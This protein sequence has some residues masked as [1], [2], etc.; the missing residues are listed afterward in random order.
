MIEN[1]AS[2]EDS[3]PEAETA[4]AKPK[5]TVK[6]IHHHH[7]KNG[8]AQINFGRIAFGLILIFIGVVY[9]AQSTGWIN[10]NFS[11]DW[12]KLW[13]LLIIIFGLSI[14]SGRGW[15]SGLIGLLVTL[16]L[17][18]IVALLIFGNGNVS[19]STTTEPISINLEAGAT[20]AILNVKAG[21]GK[22]TLTGGSDKLVDG[23][24]ES[25]S[26]DLTITSVLDGDTQ[27]VTLEEES[28]NWKN[29]GRHINDLELELDNN[30]PIKIIVNSGAMDMKLDLKDVTA[31]S[32]E[33]NTGASS[34]NLELGDK[35]ANSAVSIDAGAS[36]LT[37]NL[38]KTLGAKLNI[39]AGL[40]S[41]DLPEFNKIDDKHYESNNYSA[42]EKKVDIDLDMGVS[43]LKVNWR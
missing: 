8:G 2:P 24:F 41:K 6:E 23:T 37:L 27:T 16:A 19:T 35:I 21:A 36:S 22:L 34:M 29:L 28:F 30:L 18:A 17:L 31:E 9:L 40:S 32:V 25:N 12:W 38:P 42:S 3:K 14:I 11:F 39:D 43:S 7:Y 13:P 20:A 10:I 33:I 5:E 4:E 15:F 1:Q 26:T